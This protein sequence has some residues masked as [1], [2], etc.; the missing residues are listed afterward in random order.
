MINTQLKFEG[1]IHY[2]SKVVTFTRNHTDDDDADDADD[3][4]K[5]NMS[6]PSRW[7]GRYNYMNRKRSFSIKCVFYECLGCGSN[8]DRMGEKHKT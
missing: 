8:F 3:G 7:A 1:K 5:N 4:T 2:G 6:P